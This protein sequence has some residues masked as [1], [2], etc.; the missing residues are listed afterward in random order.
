MKVQAFIKMSAS[1]LP[2]RKGT[3]YR[4]AYGVGGYLDAIVRDLPS[5]TVVACRTNDDACHWWEH[6]PHNGNILR[7]HVVKGDVERIKRL[8]KAEVEHFDC[9]LTW[10][11]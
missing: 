4:P 7:V 5:K 3:A 2:S 1:Q 6:Q 10:A 8:V 9:E 11:N